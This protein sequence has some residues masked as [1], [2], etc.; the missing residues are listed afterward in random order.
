MCQSK[1]KAQTNGRKYHADNSDIF[2]ILNLSEILLYS[3]ITVIII[4]MI[5]L[6]HTSLIW[7]KSA[8]CSLREFFEYK[9]TNFIFA[10]TILKEHRKILCI[11]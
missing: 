6:P 10:F 7:K 11:L 4:N 1:S 3:K 9:N 5:L 8:V 2:K